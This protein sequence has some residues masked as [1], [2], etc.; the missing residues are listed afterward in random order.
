MQNV[1]FTSIRIQTI[2]KH[3]VCF[4]QS[5]VD[6]SVEDLSVVGG[7]VGPLKTCRWISGETV[8]GSVVGSFVIRPETYTG[9]IYEVLGNTL[10]QYSFIQC[11]SICSIYVMVYMVLLQYIY[12]AYI[13]IYYSVSYSIYFQYIQHYSWHPWISI[14]DEDLLFSY[15]TRMST[16]IL[17]VSKQK[18]S[19]N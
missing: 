18:F 9:K 10:K 5:V 6:G 8:G 17:F 15:K 3:F 14:S 4:I 19:L 7:P 2:L 1:I 16:T 13:I 12:I 11:Y